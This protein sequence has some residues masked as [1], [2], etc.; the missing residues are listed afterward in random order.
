MHNV[1]RSMNYRKST[2]PMV[3]WLSFQLTTI[4][5]HITKTC[6]HQKDLL[7]DLVMLN[8]YLMDTAEH[9]KHVYRLQPLASCPI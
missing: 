8:L 2:N 3:L 7:K 9:V 4:L 6:T 5:L 1:P